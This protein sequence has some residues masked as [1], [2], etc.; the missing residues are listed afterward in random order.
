ML[1]LI[2]AAFLGAWL[3][4][5]RQQ[6]EANQLPYDVFVVT[7]LNDG[8]KPAL[9]KSMLK[10]LQVV[11]GVQLC[12]WVGDNTTN[13]IW[14]AKIRLS[15]WLDELQDYKIVIQCDYAFIE[16]YGYYDYP[17]W[18]LNNTE[19][20]SQTWYNNWYGNL[21]ELLAKH[22]NVILMVGF[23]EPYN[24]FKTKE[25]AQTIM[26]R[27]YLTWKNMSTIPF[28]TEFLMPYTF[29][30]N[31]WGFPENASIEEDCVPFWRNYSDYIGVN[32]WAYRE[33]PS[34]HYI[35]LD[36]A[37]Y[38]FE[39]Y[40]RAENVIE[41]CEK[42]SEQLKKPIHINEFPVWDT[43]TAQ[44]IRDRVMK[45]PNI[46]QVY[47]LWYWSGQEEVHYDGWTYGLFNVDAKAH[48]ISEREP[49][50]SVFKEVFNPKSDSPIEEKST[51]LAVLILET[52]F[53]VL[54]IIRLDK[55][56]PRKQNTNKK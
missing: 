31:Y 14:D 11:K 55:S 6:V 48:E 8:L 10:D 4:M 26:K 37:N 13:A 50:Y 51:A 22:E 28:S 36:R 38:C 40:E 3:E 29:W 35:P 18:K 17:F 43:K 54:G 20:L 45:P 16:K 2:N 21:S 53:A 32:L 24:H 27:E 7:H 34:K 12:V 25:M 44:L 23:N 47:Q 41:I 39:A 33:P 5:K 15:K 49:S 9:I 56:L 52:V 42:Y 19:T 1:V 46:A 30:A